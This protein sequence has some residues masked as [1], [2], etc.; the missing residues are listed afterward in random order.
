MII[1]GIVVPL[2]CED[3]LSEAAVLGRCLWVP[4]NGVT[5]GDLGVFVD[6]AS[7]PVTSADG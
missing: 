4:E 6:Q 3:Q 2:T 1:R 7:E 5:S